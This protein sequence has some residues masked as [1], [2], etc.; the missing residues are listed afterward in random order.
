MD[1][2]NT[3]LHRSDLVV[4]LLVV[5]G[6]LDHSSR[7]PNMQTHT[8]AERRIYK[9]HDFACYVWNNSVLIQVY[10]VSCR[11]AGKRSHLSGA[12]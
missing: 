1:R 6:S 9:L 10:T 3:R 12:L 4:C 8:E 2:R 7:L 11:E 5:Q